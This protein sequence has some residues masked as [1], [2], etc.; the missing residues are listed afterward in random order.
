MS[1][2][3]LIATGGTGGHLF[4]AEALGAQL[5]NEKC[6]VFFAGHKLSEN[7]FFSRNFRFEDIPSSSSLKDVTTL[8]RGVKKSLRLINSFDP[9][10]VVGFGSYYSFP[11]ILAAIIKRIPIVLYA[12]DKKPGKVI[13]YLSPFAKKVGV[14]FPETLLKGDLVGMP[15][16]F[17]PTSVSKEK[18]IKYYGLDP[19]KPVCLVFGG[20][21]GAKNLN[22]LAFEALKTLPFQVIH[23]TGSPEETSIYASLYN[24]Q[25]IKAVVKTF[26]SRMEY[27]WKAA[28]IALTRAGAVSCAEEK[29]FKVPGLLIP[30]PQA[31]E[32]HQ[33]F[34]AESLKALGLCEV[35]AEK[36][37]TPQSL[38]QI[39]D[40]IYQTRKQ[41]I[42]ALKIENTPYTLKELV[43]NSI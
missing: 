43:L 18:A 35:K 24:K 14:N 17:D 28:D 41:R 10:V 4:P 12:A 39:L 37:L 1:K 34:N 2:R 11:V 31:S 16:R 22:H 5:L 23:L 29:A 3:I 8:Y 32:D 21:Q 27:A 13:R 19:N 9:Q 20:S 38:S 6:E 25:N 42:D 40:E 15:L 26:E 30:F 7:R 33:T 36:D